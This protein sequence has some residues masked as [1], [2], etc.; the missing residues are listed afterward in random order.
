MK[1]ETKLN[2]EI[3]RKQKRLKRNPLKTRKPTTKTKRK[4]QRRTKRRKVQLMIRNLL[5]VGM[6]NL[7]KQLLKVKKIRLRNQ[8]ITNKKNQKKI[9]K[10]AKYK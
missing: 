10:R 4:T 1:H 9:K 8:R 5:Q 7:I 2:K 6:P 3:A